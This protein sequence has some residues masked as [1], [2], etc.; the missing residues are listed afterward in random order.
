M[1]LVVRPTGQTMV[2]CAL[3]K[4]RLLRRSTAKMFTIR[5]EEEVKEAENILVIDVDEAGEGKTI[6]QG[7][8]RGLNPFVVV[9]LIGDQI[10]MGPGNCSTRMYLRPGRRSSTP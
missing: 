10:N 6:S 7:V 5:P 4:M 3:D 9:G 1:P 2:G 8:A